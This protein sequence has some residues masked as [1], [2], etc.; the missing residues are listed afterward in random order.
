MAELLR[1]HPLEAWGAAFDHLPGTVGITAE[2]FVAMAGIRLGADIAAGPEAAARLG[3]HLPPVP[4]TWT[5]SGAGRATWLGPDEW[6]LTSP[7]EAPEELEAL[8]MISRLD[9][10]PSGSMVCSW[11]SALDGM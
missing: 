8:R 7:T 5:P 10:N 4:N 2:P 1:T 6:L 11:S 3:T 9:D